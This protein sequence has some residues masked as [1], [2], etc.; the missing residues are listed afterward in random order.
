MKRDYIVF[1]GFW[2]KQFYVYYLLVIFDGDLS[3][4]QVI[5]G[6]QSFSSEVQKW[7]KNLFFCCCYLIVVN[8]VSIFYY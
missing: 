1:V 8:D 4:Y 7:V 2:V 5:F 3:F 6:V